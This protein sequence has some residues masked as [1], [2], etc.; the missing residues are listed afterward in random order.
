MKFTAK[1]ILYFIAVGVMSVSTLAIISYSTSKRALVDR[2]NDQLSSIKEIK[3]SQLQHWFQ[4]RLGDIKVYAFNS[5]VQMAAY[6]FISAFNEEGLNGETYQN[7]EKAHGSKLKTYI[8]EYGYYDLFFISPDGKVAYTVSKESDLGEDLING[9]LSNSVLAKAY[10]MGKEG[11]A[12]VDFEWYDVS[13]APAA[14]VTG[15]IKDN[16]GAIIGVLAYQLSLEAINRVMQEKAGLGE[17]GETY[18][19][20]EDYLLR[21][22]SRFSVESTVLKQKVDTKATQLAL[23]GQSG[24]QLITD[25]QGKDVLCSYAK[26]NIPGLNWAIIAEMDESEVLIPV[27][28]MQTVIFVAAFILLL[29]IFFVAYLVR[30]EITKTLGEEPEEIA[31][32]AENISK[33]N[34]SISFN[35]KTHFEGVYRSMYLMVNK[36]KSVVSSVISGADNIASASQHLS[37]GSQQISSGASEQAASTEEVSSSMEQMAANIQQN[38]ENAENTRGISRKSSIAMEEV[39]QA[40]EES[41]NA[42][43]DIFSKINVVVEIAEKTDLLAINAA[44][45]AARAGDEGRGFAVV[46]AEVRKLAERSQRA[47]NEIV[48]LAE[49]G[50]IKTEESANKLKAIVPEIH[51]TSRLVDEIATAS[52]EQEAGANQINSA[53]QQL[54]MVTQQ[55]ASSAEEMASSSEEMASQASELESVISFF[56]IGVKRGTGK[57]YAMGSFKEKVAPIQNSQPESVY[58]KQSMNSL[59]NLESELKDYVEM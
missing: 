39:A 1:L 41:M 28:N 8:D 42:V 44:V 12:L 4:S 34:L 25:Y 17:T 38:T 53:I 57:G 54:S 51:E 33:G 32:I 45:E 46:A 6:R 52:R 26:L 27:K 56:N 20:G 14:F 40:S 11:F 49:R 55:N 36:I 47:A 10:R 2:T 15:P 50:M 16:A 13:N 22:D 48:K 24:T 43:Q 35:Q 21:S 18:L 5:A 29:C 59:F 58:Q 9:R 7:W 19:V 23:Q 3:K 37:S 31:R 30:K